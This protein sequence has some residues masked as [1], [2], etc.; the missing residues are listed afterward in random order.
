MWWFLKHNIRFF[1]VCFPHN[2][3]FT[4]GYIVSQSTFLLLK[5]MRKLEWTCV[6]EICNLKYALKYW[7]V[8]WKELSLVPFWGMHIHMYRADEHIWP[9]SCTIYESHVFWQCTCSSSLLKISMDLICVF[10]FFFLNGQKFRWKWEVNL[11][12]ES[13]ND[14]FDFKFCCTWKKIVSNKV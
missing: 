12:T 2:D 10:F 3:E 4:S 8:N 9:H 13:H 11:D 14:L 5:I 7:F 6:L 1:C